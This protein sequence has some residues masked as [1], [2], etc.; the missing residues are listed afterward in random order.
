LASGAAYQAT[1]IQTVDQAPRTSGWYLDVHLGSSA[2]VL[3][4]EQPTPYFEPITC[5]NIGNRCR[6]RSA[7]VSNIRRSWI[8]PSRAYSV[9][10]A[11]GVGIVR[12]VSVHAA[13]L[14]DL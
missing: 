8:F 4:N 3:Q 10:Q 11:M 9:F 14:R 7:F 1:V 5:G 12:V 13:E 2:Q 6:C